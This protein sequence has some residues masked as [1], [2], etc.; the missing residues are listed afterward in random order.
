MKNTLD[1]INSRLE[2]EEEWINH[3]EDGVVEIIQDEQ[4]KEKRT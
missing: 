2:N 4:Q 1:G 3:L